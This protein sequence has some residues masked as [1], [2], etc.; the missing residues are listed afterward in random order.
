MHAS[1]ATRSRRFLFAVVLT[2]VL[3]IA[4]PVKADPIPVSAT[5][6]GN[7]IFNFDFTGSNPPPPYDSISILLALFDLE[8]PEGVALDLYRELDGSGGISVSVGP[9][10]A[11]GGND[12]TTTLSLMVTSLAL[13]GLEDGIFSFGIRITEGE[14]D[15][16][17][18]TG[19]AATTQ[20]GV[21][22][23]PIVPVV[24]APVDEPGSL[25]LL[26]AA[27]TLL[28]ARVRREDMRTVP[29]RDGRGILRG[30]S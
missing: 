24:S 9:I 29:P 13:T 8:S 5:S 20:G 19:T 17:S 3:A 27:L 2:V 4:A 22:T 10:F 16:T 21:P 11:S 23:E 18:I 6:S 26:L 12:I 15:L 28:I 7:L 14:V 25:V 1:D 30:R